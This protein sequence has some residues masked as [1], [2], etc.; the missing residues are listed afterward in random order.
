MA[1]DR[2]MKHGSRPVGNGDL[3]F[4]SRVAA[5]PP[6]AQDKTTLDSFE[7]CILL[8]AIYLHHSFEAARPVDGTA[9]ENRTPSVSSPVAQ[10]DPTL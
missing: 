8:L 9:L 1:S 7:G 4:L 10:L 5:R 6:E 2:S 3:L